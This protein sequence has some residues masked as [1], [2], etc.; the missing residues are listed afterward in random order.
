VTHFLRVAALAHAHDLPVSPV[1]NTPIGLLHAATSVPNHIASE[2]QNLKPP[3]GLSVDLW[4]EDGAFV[5][6]DSPGLGITVDETAAAAHAHRP[7]CPSPG[8]P[9]VR[10]ERAGQRLL[11][12][13]ELPHPVR[14]QLTKQGRN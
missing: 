9:H 11:T 14:T 7:D 3:V 12:D 4:I 2:L 6:G 1:G 13:A 10:P 5:L 8:G